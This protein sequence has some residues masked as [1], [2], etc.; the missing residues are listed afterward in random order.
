MASTVAPAPDRAPPSA[1]GPADPRGSRRGPSSAVPPIPLS[2][3]LDLALLAVVVGV[4]TWMRAQFLAVGAPL[5][6]TPDSD[7][8]LRPAYDLAHGLGFEPELRRTP[9]YSSF[10]AAVLAAGGDLIAVGVAQ[11]ALGALTAAAAFGLGRASYGRWAGLIAGLAVAVSGPLLIY[12]HY[13]M[14]ESLFTLLLTVAALILIV[15][16]RE[17]GRAWLFAAGVAFGLAALTRPVGQA[18]IPV[19]LGLPVVL[20]LPRWRDGARRAALVG[21]GLLIVLLPWMLRNWAIHGAFG[22]EGALGQALIG[23]TVRHDRGFVYDD[24]GRPEP[25]PTRAAARRIIQ[26]EVAGG[27]PSGGTITARVRDELGLSQA[28][29]SSLLRELA[30][31]AIQQRP[32]PYLAST[33]ETIWELFQGKNERLLGHWRQR[34]TRNWDRRWDPR[35]VPLLGDELPASGPAYERADE[36][37][38]TFQ[39]WRWRRP[40]AWL[41]GLGVVLALVVRRW[42]LG[43]APAAVA[44]VLVVAAAALDGLVWRFRYPA[45]PLIAVVAAGGLTASA[46][47][48]WGAA[49]RLARPTRGLVT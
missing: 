20:A 38:S 40:I 16:L 39:P 30:I 8:Y 28:Q 14:A 12:E 37:T 32:G 36:L 45:D 42:R 49:R 2:V 7:D 48:V 4:A 41:F 1:G 22:A 3:A 23:R 43:L 21:L 17:R 33:A 27:E 5:F 9:L 47:L 11:H 34:T 19:A 31:D 26:E 13:L 46:T 15:A 24:P 44:V 6:V 10:V 29:T 18:A 35:L 25:D